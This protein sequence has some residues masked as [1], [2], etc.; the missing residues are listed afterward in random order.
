MLWAGTSCLG[1]DFVICRSCSFS[2]ASKVPGRPGMAFELRLNPGM[3]GR[4]LPG[5]VPLLW[6]SWKVPWMAP[7]GLLPGW[8]C[9]LNPL[10]ERNSLSLW[11]CCGANKLPL[12]LPTL[13]SYKKQQSGQVTASWEESHESEHNGRRG[14]CIYAPGTLPGCD[15]FERCTHTQ[16]TEI[17]TNIQMC[18]VVCMRTHTYT[19]ILPV[20]PQKCSICSSFFSKGYT[21]TTDGWATSQCSKA[22]PRILMHPTKVTEEKAGI[23]MAS[24]LWL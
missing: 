1:L 8:I 10:L 20:N 23:C 24:G 21:Q 4:Y 6:E 19:H 22:S 17:H 5:W 12:F 7:S 2:K 11:V 16:T 18:V 15:S 14:N 13:K 9:V 3:L